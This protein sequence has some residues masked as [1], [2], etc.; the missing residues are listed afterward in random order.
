MFKRCKPAIFLMALSLALGAAACGP[1][2][3]AAS[4]TAAPAALANPTN[5]PAATS[6][7][8]AVGG[9]QPTPTATAP[10]AIATSAATSLAPGTPDGIVVGQTRAIKNVSG[11]LDKLK[12][13]RVHFTYAF[14]GKD[15]TGQPRTESVEYSQD[16]INATQDHHLKIVLTGNAIG[17]T[18]N[19]TTSVGT[20]GGYESY[21]V[22]GN[23]FSINQGK[24]QFTSSGVSTTTPG[25]LFSLDTFI[26][27][28]K[29][30]LIRR[31][32]SVNGINTD[33]YTFTEAAVSTSLNGMKLVQGDAW[34][35]AD[36]YVVKVVGQ[37]SGKA[38]DGNEGVV[39]VSYNLDNVNN[40]SPI[41]LPADCVV[42]VQVADVPI[43]PNATE[44]KVFEA[45]GQ[46]VT[47]FKSP[48]PIKTV[49]DF[50]RQAMP[51]QGWTAAGDKASGAISIQLTYTK[52]AGKRTLMIN[53]I[54]Q[55]GVST[56]RITDTKSP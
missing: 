4:P 24:C 15:K 56:V 34:V 25:A 11:G 31:G 27:A 28:D 23:T 26:G 33:H 52:D 8:V 51:A 41:I 2:A 3:P 12:S 49:A 21:Q 14:D 30:T 13:Y 10:A 19:Y 22:G 17:A 54:T 43:P 50:Y 20:P 7:G 29:A 45:G 18:S 36:G 55:V 9:G 53:V 1:F 46:T 40:V 6:G 37:A 35:A 5:A 42:P 48:D 32:E 47:T 39:N 38:A 16:V 44:K